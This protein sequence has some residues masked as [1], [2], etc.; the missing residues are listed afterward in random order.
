MSNE[1]YDVLIVGGGP[2]GASAGIHLAA[3]GARVLLA[4]RERFPRPKL[5]GEFISPECLAHFARLGV[6]ERMTAAGGAAVGE[7]IFYTRSGRSAAVPSAWLGREEQRALGLSRAEMDAQLLA[8]A[9]EVGV[10]VLEGAQAVGLVMEDGGRVCGVR[11]NVEGETVE[12]RAALTVDATGRA[13]ALVRFVERGSVEGGAAARRGRAPHVAFKA[14]LEGARARVGACE[15]YFYRGGYGGLSP[16]EGDLSNLCFIARAADVRD[17]GSDPER[18]MREVLMTN[19]RAARALEGARP[20]SAWLSVALE[21]FGRRE[22][23][24]ARGLLAVGDAASFIDPFTGS[25]MLM[26]LESGE[27]AAE[28]ITR[29]LGRGDVRAGHQKVFDELAGDYR[30]RY[31]ERF[32]A[33]LRLCGWLRRAAFAPRAFAEMAVFALGASAPA[34]R[35]IARATRGT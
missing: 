5:C 12:R 2:A 29:R 1:T 14:H 10:E 8:R 6:A 19:R 13:H 4:E 31:E 35:R 18:V 23:A 27:L 34:R 21:G 11:L 17:C 22:P 33:R 20:A 9:R 7:T 16:V 32:G 15:I 25:G 3:R 26:A 24:P 30:M 28:A